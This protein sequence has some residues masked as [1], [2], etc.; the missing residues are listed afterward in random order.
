MYVNPEMLTQK[1]ICTPVFTAVLVPMVKIW[2][3]H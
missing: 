3:Y 1:N 2:K